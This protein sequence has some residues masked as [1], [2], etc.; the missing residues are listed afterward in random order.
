MCK[1]SLM[2][3]IE[4]TP[5]RRPPPVRCDAAAAAR[6]WAGIRRSHRALAIALAI[7]GTA[8][9]LFAQA[10]LTLE[11]ALNLASAAHPSVRARLSDR[12]GAE[13]RVDAAR[14]QRY[15]Q[16]SLQAAAG[17][18]GKQESALQVQVPLWVAG[19]IDAEVNAAELRVDASTA[20]VAGAQLAI[21]ETVLTAYGELA[22]LR[23]R[24][25][26][27]AAS[28]EQHA[29]LVALMERRVATEIS[30]Q[31]DLTLARARLSQVQGELRQIEAQAAT[32]RSSLEQA[33]G[34]AVPAT[35]P[36]AARALQFTDVDAAVAAAR[37][38][39]P[40]LRR[41]L[42][43]IDA[44]QRDVEAR[45]AARYPQ[46]VARYRYDVSSG[47]GGGRHQAL[48]GLDYQSGPGFSAAAAVRESEARVESL[49]LEYETQVQRL[50]ERARTDWTNARMLSLQAGEYERALRSTREFAESTDRQFVIGRKS[51]IE[52]LNAYREV[53]QLA[54]SVA[55]AYWSAQIA[56]HRLHLVTGLLRPAAAPAPAPVPS[57]ASSPASVPAPA[58]VPVGA[59]AR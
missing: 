19:R 14:W 45:R 40:E 50:A 12:T 2:T 25:A 34:R 49:R 31:A 43:E 58:A 46:V 26:A 30:S 51:W 21:M 39:S 35:G 3:S 13:A 23:D 36:M 32:A 7:A 56:V 17:T 28:V 33:V 37:E 44:A 11:E 47:T 24:G 48:L 8:P 53:A 9:S 57:A 42:R 1:L 16:V 4:L 20:A 29:R 6:P 52:V 55:D 10:A 59:A 22:R 38:A 41:L 15:P 54:Q 27:V 18:L 5:G